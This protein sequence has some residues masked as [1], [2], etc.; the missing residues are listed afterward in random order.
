MKVV[1]I[2]HC[3]QLL[4][5]FWGGIFCHFGPCCTPNS[6]ILWAVMYLH[7]HFVKTNTNLKQYGWISYNQFDQNDHE[8]G[9]ENW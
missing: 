2:L 7:A 5:L 3:Q 8:Y 1:D 4:K 6:V 9:N